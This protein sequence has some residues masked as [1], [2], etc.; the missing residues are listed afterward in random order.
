[1]I[2]PF[3]QKSSADP[4]KVAQIKTWVMQVFDLSKEHSVMVS[5]LHCTEADCPPLETVIAIMSV[6]EPTKQQK[7]FKAIKEV[8]LN[9][10][11]DLVSKH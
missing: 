3:S 11:K 5:E 6:G 1:M 7:I 8:T 10:L 4:A 2:N 9:D